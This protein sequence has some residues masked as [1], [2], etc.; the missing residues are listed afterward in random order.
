MQ[1]QKAFNLKN[2]KF[3]FPSGFFM[4]SSECQNGD[5]NPFH[6]VKKIHNLF[7]SVIWV[8]YILFINLNIYTMDELL[9]HIPFEGIT[10]KDLEEKTTNSRRTIFR[11][12]EK[13]IEEGKIYKY[14][15]LYKKYRETPTV[16]DIYDKMMTYHQQNLMNYKYRRQVRD[17][18]ADLTLQWVMDTEMVIKGKIVEYNQQ[19]LEDN[20]VI[21]FNTFQRE[22]NRG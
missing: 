8:D 4:V 15:G 6:S 2:P 7:D 14:E 13:L 5:N 17:A 3:K 19:E 10:P 9:E 11:H 20:L 16:G 18:Q 1:P 22:L 12:L 21:A